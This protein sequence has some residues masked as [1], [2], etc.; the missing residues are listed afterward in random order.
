[1]LKKKLITIILLT[2]LFISPVVIAHVPVG[3]G[4]NTSIETATI[5]EE[6]TK[7]W[8]IYDEIHETSE[9]KYYKF[10][11]E[12]DQRLKIQLYSPDQDFSPNLI[13]ME[14]GTTKD[15]NIPEFIEIPDNYG[16]SIF[17]GQQ[18]DEKE[19][20]PFTPASYYYILDFDMNVN[21]TGDYYLAVYSPTNHGKI[22]I[23]IGYVET[24][25]AIEW[26]RIPI[27][28][29]NIHIWEGQNLFLILAPMILSI[30][31]GIA[32][33]FY[34]KLTKNFNL[35][36]W[37]IY[38]TGLIYLGS[39]L[40][41]LAQMIFAAATSSFGA[42]VLITSIF[43]IIPIILGLILINMS[44]K[45]IE[46]KQRMTII[47]LL[48]IGIL[49]IIFWSGLIIGPILSIISAFISIKK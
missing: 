7:S 45:K 23:A 24:F 21:A 43:I 25:S 26:I 4:E 49:G 5:V 37:M 30:I 42:G 48:L 10:H 33:I 36:K 41:I 11:M 13:L 40:I 46:Q 27:D 44:M 1:M 3:V 19:Y 14:P 39:G 15:E 32:L 8:A 31:V 34:K 20:E 2:F 22:G 17:Y 35:K 18:S 12:A 16:A 29:I 47:K 28:T 6:P 38:I 9:A